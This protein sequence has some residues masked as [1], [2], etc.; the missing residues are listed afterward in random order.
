MASPPY[1]SNLVIDNPWGGGGQILGL[2]TSIIH[3]LE[4]HIRREMR[5]SSSGDFAS[6]SS[7]DACL[8]RD[9]VLTWED[10]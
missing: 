3:C 4:L 10:L 8:V 5:L 1:R 9:V 6:L 7:N 2:I